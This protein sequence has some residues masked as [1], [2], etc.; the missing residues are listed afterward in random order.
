MA[1]LATINLYLCAIIF[2][3][4][5][6]TRI[7]FHQIEFNLFDI[8]L[9][10]LS[11]LNLFINL[12]Q[13]KSITS[14]Y[15]LHFLFFAWVSYFFNLLL[16]KNFSLKPFLYLIRLSSYLSF[17][18]Y[19]LDKK[20]ISQKFH[21]FFNLII[22]SNISFGFVQYIFWPNFTYFDSLNWDP[23]LYRLISTFFDPTFTA[24]IYLFFI[25]DLFLNQ[26]K[27]SFKLLIPY[28]ALSLTYSRSSL[29]SL[30]IVSIFVSFKLKKIKIFL[31][32]FIFLLFTLI[33]LPRLSGEGTKLERTSSIFAKIE[34]YQ[35]AFQTFLKSPIIGIGYNNIGLLRP[36]INPNS[37]ANWGFDG[38]LMTILATTGILGLLLFTKSS[39]L[40]F[41]NSNLIFQTLFIALL[42]H[43]LFANSM[44]YPWIIFYIIIKNRK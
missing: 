2:F 14:K 42:I 27:F 31:I 37:H 33:L 44:L 20:I 6:L 38:S 39:I 24:L 15:F 32:T 23:H 18:I 3:F 9:L 22:L 43:S 26:K 17:F 40:F 4:G 25:I 30:S 10:S 12:K 7:K 41:Y 5:Q 36:N 16:L 13:K 21:R 1:S 29:L 19:P 8:S 28:L 34:N 35:E 11:L